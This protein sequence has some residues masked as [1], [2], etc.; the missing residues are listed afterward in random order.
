MHIPDGFVSGPINIATF[1]VS[2]AVCGVAVARANR[3]L[4][5]RQVPLLGVTAAFVF[6]AQMLNFPIAIGTSGHFMGAVLAAIL[7]GPLNAVLILGLVLTIQ[8]LLFADGGLS[9]LGSNI[10]NMGI[11]GGLGGYGVFA[12]LRAA[13]PKTRRCFLASAAAAAWASIVLAAAACAV[14]IGLSGTYPL[15]ATLPAMTGVHV[16]IGIGEGLITTVTLS[17]VLASRPDL[18]P[19]WR[20]AAQEA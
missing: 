9:A 8:C 4:G 11:V 18:V 14:E 12:L 15:A 6:A 13:L 5:E 20:P 7:L 19:A 10:F 3:T 17:L 2:A 1:A 16:L